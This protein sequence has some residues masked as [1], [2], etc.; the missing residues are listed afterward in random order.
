MDEHELYGVPRERFIAERNALAKALRADGRREEAAGVAAL[1]KPSVAAATVNQLVRDEPDR[2]AA[3]LQAGDALRTAQERMLSGDGTAEELRGAVGAERAAVDALVSVAAQ[4]GM[5]PSVSDRV[6]ATLHAAALDEEA[7][8]RVSGGR[9]VE[10]L[11]H[12]GFGAGSPSTGPATAK[13]ASA[14]PPGKPARRR[15]ADATS[16]SRAEAKRDQERE[17]A[18]QRRVAEERKLA[19]HAERETRRRLDA[20]ERALANADQHHSR[21][22]AELQDAEDKLEAARA[23]ATAASA[24]HDAAQQALGALSPATRR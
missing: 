8:G 19:R 12:V 7:R 20:A 5:N 1:R 9:L 14:Q 22:R 10:E 13:P 21:V 4:Q 15:Q 11:Q 16:P 17:Q 3:L 23:E 18:E 6:A 24:A 2:L